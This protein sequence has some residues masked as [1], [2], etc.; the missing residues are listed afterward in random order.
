MGFLLSVSL[1]AA[2]TALA[3]CI[4]GTVLVLRRQA[5]MSDALA[6][7]VLP[8][9][10]IAAVVA[11]ASPTSPV[12]VVGATLSGVA[13]MAL[14][15]LLRRQSK[16]TE[17]GA[18]GLVFPVFF[19]IGVILISTR[20]TSSTISEHS[21][22]MGDL[23]LAAFKHLKVAG[24]DLGPQEMWLV[25]AVGLFAAVVL[26]VFRRPLIISTFDPVFAHTIGI[27][28]RVLDYAIMTLV[29]LTVVVCFHAAGAVLVVALM[30]V[31]PAAALLVSRSLGSMVIITAVVAI[32]GSQLGF[33]AAYHLNAA[34]AP[35][36]AMVD[37]LLFICA[38]AL[39]QVVQR[40]RHVAP[41]DV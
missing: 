37:G 14:T 21:V 15:E 22:L 30:I 17:D 26:F 10:A 33:W 24:H 25:G 38:W 35:M 5:M 13:V 9:I 23:N 32:A 28:T 16:F 2:A 11:G 4:P 3:C 36:M 27:S 12:L 39:T 7:A 20:L 41:A 29:S 1:L 8:G 6:H 40:R 19:S 31:P 18:T 34:T